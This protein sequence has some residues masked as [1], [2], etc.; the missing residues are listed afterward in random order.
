MKF[1]PGACG[2]VE[3]T[4]KVITGAFFAKGVFRVDEKCL[5]GISH[6]KKYTW[7]IIYS[8]IV[9]NATFAMRPTKYIWTPG[10]YLGAGYT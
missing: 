2:R 5:P 10:I 1:I 3:R 4:I 9:E 6:A 8:L 7:F